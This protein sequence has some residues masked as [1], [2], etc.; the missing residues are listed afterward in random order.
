MVHTYSVEPGTGPPKVPTPAGG[1]LS[2]SSA[3]FNL[4]TSASLE[5]SLDFVPLTSAS[6]ARSRS[7]SCVAPRPDA[8]GPVRAGCHAGLRARGRS[9]RPEGRKGLLV[10][11]EPP[12]CGTHV[13]EALGEPVPLN[14]HS[15][16][17]RFPASPVRQAA[18]INWPTRAQH[19]QNLSLVLPTLA[20][21]WPN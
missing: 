6:C 12:S 7:T 9:R 20:E 3:S 2:H 13:N 21:Y 16:T 14:G 8:E 18:K 4:A 1:G 10:A 19:R 17:S 5:A 15:T 11:R